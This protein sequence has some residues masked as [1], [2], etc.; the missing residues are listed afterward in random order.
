MY[1]AQKAKNGLGILVSVC[2]FLVQVEDISVALAQLEGM[3]KLG[4]PNT[5]GP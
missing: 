1:I 2:V 5:A 4:S 3:M